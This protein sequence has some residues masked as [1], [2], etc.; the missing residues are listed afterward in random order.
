VRDRRYKTRLTSRVA[1]AKRASCPSYKIPACVSRKGGKLHEI[2][3]WTAEIG[4][5]SYNL[6]RQAA[7]SRANL[8]KKQ[9][10]D[11]PAENL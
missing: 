10:I 8:Y 5:K 3:Q 11:F 6:F 4:H 9:V 7:Y 2:G 1:Q